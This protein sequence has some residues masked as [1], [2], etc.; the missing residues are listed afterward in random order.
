MWPLVNILQWREHVRALSKV[1][2]KQLQAIVNHFAL[3]GA[4]TDI[5]FQG[6]VVVAR[7]RQS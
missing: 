5:N 4:G 1:G 2:K 6:R 7:G 3:N